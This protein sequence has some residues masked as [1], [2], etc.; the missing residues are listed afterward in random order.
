MG[1]RF[2]E[3]FRDT[4]QCG[5]VGSRD[6]DQCGPVGSRGYVEEMVK[7]LRRQIHLSQVLKSVRLSRNRHR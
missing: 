7:T 6:T 5:P 2:P 4:D 3:L 1:K